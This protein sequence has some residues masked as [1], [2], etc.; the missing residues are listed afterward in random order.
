[1]SEPETPQKRR[2][3]WRKAGLIAGVVLVTAAGA[4]GLA[5]A[6]AGPAPFIHGCLK[7]GTARDFAEFRMQK[8]LKKVNATDS[9]QQQILAI[10]DG[11]FA[12]HQ[13]MAS[14]H[15]QLHQQILAALTA[16]TV[17]R[18]ALEAV[19]LDVVSRIDQGSK[20]VAR[21]LGDMAEVLTPA[22]RQQLQ[23]LAQQHFQ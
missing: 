14:V 18:T 3:L 7:P 5:R 2:R 6:A 23:A 12:K 16:P 22:Q 17:N 10:L 21:A 15:E 8:V 4:V 1:M 19:R 9:Q 20:D 11:M 13:A